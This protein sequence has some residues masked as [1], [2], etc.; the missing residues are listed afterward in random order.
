MTHIS[1]SLLVMMLAN[2]LGAYSHELQ[3]WFYVT[4]PD[5]ILL[6]FERTPADP[7]YVDMASFAG[8]TRTTLLRFQERVL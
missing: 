1:N 2:L 8:P 6:G 4:W 3:I 7:D 5:Q